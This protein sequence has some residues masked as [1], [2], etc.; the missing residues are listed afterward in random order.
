MPHKRALG[1]TA[2]HKQHQIHLNAGKINAFQFVH[3]QRL[4]RVKQ[5]VDQHYDKRLS[6]TEVAAIAGL[7]KTYFSRYFHQKIGICYND[8]LHWIRISQAIELMTKH[9]L[10]VT[11]IAF[12][13]GYR[14]LRTFERAFEKLT[15]EC[16]SQVKKTLNQQGCD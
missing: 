8:W 4:K 12:S 2:V 11:T 9:K 3:D 16:P 7:E 1:Q 14:D 5:Y 13:V 10:S 6:L 15:G